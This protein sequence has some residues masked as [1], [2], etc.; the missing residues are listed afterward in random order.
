MGFVSKV[1]PGGL[2]GVE[3]EAVRMGGVVAEKSP[4]A[5]LGTKNIL[6]C[7]FETSLSM[8]RDAKGNLILYRTHTILLRLEGSFVSRPKVM[9]SLSSGELRLPS[10]SIALTT[11]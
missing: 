8:M 6:N 11:A 3:E 7:E 2:R 4:V 9:P 5:V 1:V 10:L